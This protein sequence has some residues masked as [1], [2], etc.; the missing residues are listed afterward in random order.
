MNLSHLPGTYSICRLR[1][2]QEV[3]E[4]VTGPG[5]Y[6]VTRSDS[7]L[8]ILCP[9]GRVPQ[10]VKQEGGW[11]GIVVE[12]PLDFNQIGI[13]ASLLQPLAEAQIPVFVVS[14]YD[15]DALFLKR[16]FLQRAIETLELA[17][18]DLVGSSA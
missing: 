10:D 2:D 12:G 9:S 6:S 4:W 13:L 17:G 7:E 16:E 1:S 5:Y 3:P 18:H 11:C 8:S 14:S 15:T